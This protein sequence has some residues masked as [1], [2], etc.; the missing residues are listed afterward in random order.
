M[1][2]VIQKAEEGEVSGVKWINKDDIPKYVW[3][4]VYFEIL[5]LSY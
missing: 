3:A 5:C 1:T 2:V 4:S